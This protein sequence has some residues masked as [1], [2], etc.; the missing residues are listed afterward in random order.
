MNNM[1]AFEENSLFLWNAGIIALRE[2]CPPPQI[3]DGHFLVL[4]LLMKGATWTCSAQFWERI[5]DPE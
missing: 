3:S 2:R 5:Q 4:I 1:V